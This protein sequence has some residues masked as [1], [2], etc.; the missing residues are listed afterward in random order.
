MNMNM[1]MNATLTLTLSDRL[2]E[3]LE[4][5]LP[6]LGKRMK[7]AVKKEIG[8]ALDSDSSLD[9][10]ITPSRSAEGETGQAAC[11]TADEIEV[12]IEAKETVPA[13]AAAAAPAAAPTAA[14]KE[15][16]PKDI[17]PMIREIIDRTRRRIEGDDYDL[18]TTSEA[19]QRYHKPLSDILIEIANSLGYKKP[20]LINTAEALAQFEKASSEIYINDKGELDTETPF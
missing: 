18:N 11:T 7:R 5:K 8:N 15:I 10:K 17:P 12:K 4:D 6:N 9:I 2:F 13:P 3:L 16:D 20:S 1:N 19:R 14:A